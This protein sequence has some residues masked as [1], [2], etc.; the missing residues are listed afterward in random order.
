[1]GGESSQDVHNPGILAQ[2]DD[3]IAH[4]AH[5]QHQDT[6]PQEHGTQVLQG[7]FFADD[8][9][10]KANG[11]DQG[12]VVGQIEGNE[13]CGHGGPDVGPHDDAECLFQV[14]QS[15]VDQPHGH[16]RGSTGRLE[17]CRNPGPQGHPVDSLLCQLPQDFLELG[18]SRLLQAVA[19]QL[20]TVQEKRNAA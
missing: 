9:H 8:L 19:H 13:L 10:H 16:N 14:H 15:C 17:H 12:D 11:N 18:P 3:G 6:K 2:G 7:P 4:H 20:H 1:M 5:A